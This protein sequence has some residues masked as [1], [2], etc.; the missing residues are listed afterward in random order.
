MSNLL[1]RASAREAKHQEQD[2]GYLFPLPYTGGKQL[3]VLRIPLAT[4]TQIAGL[5]SDM[6]VQ[7][8]DLI[9]EMRGGNDFIAQTW[10]QLTKNQKRQLDLANAMTVAGAIAPRVFLTEPEAN[11][12]DPTGEGAVCVDDID[13]RDRISY[14]YSI[15]N[16]ESEAAKVMAP[17]PGERLGSG[18]DRQVVPYAAATF[19]PAETAEGI[20]LVDQAVPAV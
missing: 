2:L 19:P 15:L 6:Q 12:F 3:R 4:V 9:R 10:E 5:S 11:S 7:L 18:A 13:P 14:L 1:N 20:R 17:F 8:M 16:P